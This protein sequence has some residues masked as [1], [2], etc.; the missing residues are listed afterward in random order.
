MPVLVA[1]SHA[2]CGVAGRNAKGEARGQRTER[3]RVG[4]RRDRASEKKRNVFATF[5]VNRVRRGRPS[6]RQALVRRVRRPP[7]SPDAVARSTE[8]TDPTE[9]RVGRR[10]SAIKAARGV[11][12]SVETR[13]R[14]PRVSARVSARERVAK[15]FGSASRCFRRLDGRSF[16]R[17]VTHLGVGVLG[18][19]GSRTPSEICRDACGGW[20]VSGAF[21]TRRE[22]RGGRVLGV[23]AARFWTRGRGRLAVKRRS[24]ERERLHRQVARSRTWSASLSG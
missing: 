24:V 8:P 13:S 20:L 23:A 3:R 5:V 10:R 1:V 17:P 2:T 15:N 16:S 22:A 18:E 4:A 14:G 7:R 21:E 9:P 12:A 11:R 6:R 19:A